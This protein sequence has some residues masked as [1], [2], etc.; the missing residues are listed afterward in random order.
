MGFYVYKYIHLSVCLSIYSLILYPLL[1]DLELLL[2][3]TKCYSKEWN[4]SLGGN[5]FPLLRVNT[6]EPVSHLANGSPIKED[7][8]IIIYTKEV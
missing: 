1:S 3:K 4:L 5:M 8:S 6:I 2:Q 7:E